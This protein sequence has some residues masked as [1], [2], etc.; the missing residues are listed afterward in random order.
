[1]SR[2]T[3]HMPLKNPYFSE[4]HSDGKEYERGMLAAVELIKPYLTS[5]Q[6]QDLLSKKL[7]LY[8]DSINEPQYIQAACEL[9]ICSYIAN[10][11]PGSFKYEPKLNPP[12]DVDC[13]FSTENTTYNIEIKCA[14]YTKSN[15][16]N[17]TKEAYHIGFMGRLP[18]AEAVY[19]DLS[20][21]FGNGPLGASLLKQQHMD[22]K[23]KDFLQSAHGKFASTPSENNLNVLAVCCD[24]AM[25]MQK[26]HS[27]MFGEQGLFKNNS[28]ADHATYNRVDAVLLTNIFHRHHEFFKKGRIKNHWHLEDSFSLLFSNPF[29]LLDKKNEFFKLLEAIPNYSLAIS[30]YQVPGEV[31]DFIK[32]AL[33]IPHFIGDKL[34]ASQIFCFQPLSN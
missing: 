9:V 27:Y 31:E 4:N 21:L 6:L 32:D 3:P 24:T 16:I 19:S 18:N 25:D 11:F 12:K 23:L 30:E 13:A 5:K 22:N 10:K 17:N 2:T 14:D 8:N 26:W 33:R 28:F 34:E 1:M 29:R 15:D 20:Q 7:Q